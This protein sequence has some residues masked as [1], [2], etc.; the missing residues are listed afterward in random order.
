[1]AVLLL[2]VDATVTTSI[3][4]ENDE[5]IA[6]QVSADESVTKASPRQIKL[7]KDSGMCAAHHFM[8]TKAAIP[9]VAFVTNVVPIYRYPIFEQLHQTL[10]LKIQILV[11]V[12][13]S[14]SCREAIANL[15]IRYS[16]S[17][18]LRY[19]TTH[20]STGA[21]QRE[22]LSIPLAVLTD[23]IK[24]RPDVVVSGDLGARSLV[25]WFAA[26]MVGARFV[27]WSEDIASSALGRSRLQQWLRRFLVRR[28]DAFLA[29][30]DPA[31]RYLT[32]LNVPLDRIFDCAQAIDNEYW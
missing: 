19:T 22:P 2:I 25:C 7:A 5:K 27:L 10:R 16:A 8:I 9:N 23:L 15:P 14:Q 26:K 12:P 28:A 17:I 3:P 18:N 30:G 31:R 1:M 21:S 6:A 20:L 32:S 4:N 11:T 13:L 29:W 24:C